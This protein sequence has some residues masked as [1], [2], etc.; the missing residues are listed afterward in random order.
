MDCVHRFLQ[1]VRCGDH[2][3][4]SVVDPFSEFDEVLEFVL[5]SGGALA[6]LG[7]GGSMLGGF[8]L[9]VGSFDGG[10]DTCQLA[11]VRRGFGVQLVEACA[12]FLVAVGVAS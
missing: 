5:Q 4:E 9:L 11:G 3:I 1:F 7:R 2:D 10:V 6:I 8:Q 12:G